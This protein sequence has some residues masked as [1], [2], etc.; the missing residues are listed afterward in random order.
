MAHTEMDWEKRKLELITNYFEENKEV[1][2]PLNDGTV[3][4]SKEWAIAVESH[5]GLVALAESE[6]FDAHM[7]RGISTCGA[8]RDWRDNQA[9]CEEVIARIQER[10]Y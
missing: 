10:G 8:E 7:G 3:W 2:P 1:R 6:I 9:K 5:A 4:G